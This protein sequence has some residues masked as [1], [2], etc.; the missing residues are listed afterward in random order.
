MSTSLKPTSFKPFLNDLDAVSK[1]P[2]EFLQW[3]VKFCEA[4]TDNSCKNL[5][6][7][8]SALYDIYKHIHILI[9]YINLLLICITFEAFSNS[10]NQTSGSGCLFPKSI[11]PIWSGLGIMHVLF[12]TTSHCTN[13]ASWISPSLGSIQYS[14]KKKFIL[15]NFNYLLVIQKGCPGDT[16]DGVSLL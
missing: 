2:I 11:G 14:P 3:Y 15:Y 10:D 16:G 9:K 5:I 13:I 1:Y 12:V 4:D 8:L 6:W 7:I